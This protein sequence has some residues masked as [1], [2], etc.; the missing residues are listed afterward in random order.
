MTRDD[1]Q[2]FADRSANEYAK[3]IYREWWWLAHRPE[4]VR[5][6]YERRARQDQINKRLSDE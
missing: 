5:Y 2:E 3:S 1:I 6:L 4:P